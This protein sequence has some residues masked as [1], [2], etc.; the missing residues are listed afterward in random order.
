MLRIRFWKS[1]VI[2]K[3]QAKHRLQGLEMVEAR[4]LLATVSLA[5]CRSDEDIGANAIAPINEYRTSLPVF[6]TKGD[7]QPGAGDD[8]PRELDIPILHSKPGAARTIYLDFD[9]Q[10]IDNTAWNG[11]NNDLPIHAPP[12]S[13]N[14]NIFNFNSI[15]IENIRQIHARV[16]EDFLPF[17]VDVTTENPGEAKFL[18]GGQA[19]RVLISTDVDESAMGGTGNNWF[20]G[21]GGVAF[22]NSWNWTDGSPVWV[23]E[24]NLGNGD[25]KNVAEASSHE[26]GHAFGLDHDGTTQGVEYY[27][28]HGSSTTGWAPIMGVGYNQAVTQW[29]RGE[30][31]NANNPEDD[32][33]IITSQ[34]GNRA[35]DHANGK[36]N[37]AAATT[38]VDNAGVVEGSGIIGLRTDVDVFQLTLSVEKRIQMQ[39]NP[40]RQGPNLDILAEL[41]SSNGSLVASSNP[42]NSLSS[43]FDLTLPPG[44]YTLAIDGVGLTGTPATGY[45]DYASLGQYSIEATLSDID[46][47]P[48]PL[49]VSGTP[50]FD[51]LAN[52][53]SLT[54][55][56]N[57]PIDVASVELLQDISL[58][59]EASDVTALIESVSFPTPTQLQL[60][61]LVPLG[62]IPGTMEL[63]VGPDIRELS[64]L[65]MDQDGDG[66]P[67]E[68]PAD[69]FQFSFTVTA[70]V[71]GDFNSDQLVNAVDIDLLCSAIQNA[72]AIDL[73]DLNQDQALN[74][75]DMDVMI[76]DVLLTEYGDANLDRFVDGSDFGIWNAHKF[77]NGG[78]ANGDFSCDGIID[79][80]D[81]G[82][83]NANKFTGGVAVRTPE[84]VMPSFET[85]LRSH[86]KN[87][88][89]SEPRT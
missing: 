49:F 19:L 16:A 85:S 73:Y 82:I 84:L 70:A 27:T 21:A 77:Q 4:C 80:S 43:T 15:E 66:V 51:N 88:F 62:M 87:R 24:N 79:G 28:G 59:R 65:A 47:N 44:I 6:D 33:A 9:G 3:K 34:L 38:L 60:N 61:F 7:E 45:T 56:F 83:W 22:L 17:D 8:D 76:R 64:G 30:Y 69:V 29:S 63:R 37:A 46:P 42:A 58:F 67:G 35:D 74:A 54:I 78:W 2:K 72:G 71:R 75:L 10:I 68:N 32:I 53:T 39:I 48:G 23:F 81:F 11:F 25:A 41:F 26:A 1:R 18:A 12:Y 31:L 13:I 52:P 50:L 40:A 5:E 86:G 14:A 36:T 89:R 20:S 57:E 55:P